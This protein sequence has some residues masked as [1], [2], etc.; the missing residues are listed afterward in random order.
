MFRHSIR[1]SFW[2]SI[3][4]TQIPFFGILLTI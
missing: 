3:Y 2:H 4:P 1:H